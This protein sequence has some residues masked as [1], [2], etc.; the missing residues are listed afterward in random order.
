MGN[1]QDAQK[2][3]QKKTP[4]E[5]VT[6]AAEE[7]M[8]HVKVINPKVKQSRFAAFW[9]LS[10][11][12]FKIFVL[13]PSFKASSIGPVIYF[14]FFIVLLSTGSLSTMSSLLYT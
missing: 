11:Q 1:G 3:K 4:H 14:L 8:H 12:P 7:Y 5:Q 6:A 2:T 10:I 9:W 13:F